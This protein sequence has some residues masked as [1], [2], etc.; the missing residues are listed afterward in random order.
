MASGRIAAAVWIVF[1]SA[2]CQKLGLVK[3]YEYDERVELSLDGS[4]IVD[5]NASIPALVALRGVDPGRRPRSALRQAGIPPC[6]R[7]ARGER[8]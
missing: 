1:V 3:Q 8:S 6:V 5:L 4:A 7:G 2:A